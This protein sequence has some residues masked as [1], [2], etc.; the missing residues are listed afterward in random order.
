MANNQQEEIDVWSQQFLLPDA[1]VY[2]RQW[3]Q[4]PPEVAA[5]ITPHELLNRYL[6]HIRRCTFAIIR[7][8]NIEG[9]IQFR[10]LDS[11]FSLL[12]FAPPEISSDNRSCSVD[13]CLS[14]GLLVQAAE[15][16][17]GRFCLSAEKNPEGITVV[18]QLSDYCPLLLGSRKPSRLRKVF[19]RLTQAY[20]HKVVTVRFLGNLYRNLTGKKLPVKVHKLRTSS[21]EEI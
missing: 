5:A 11:G 3:L 7:P 9:A 12:T 2:S 1:S 10:L 16:D 20:I 18:I 4:L 13:L 6:D 8:A 19:Y 14:G 17:R 21:G 15:C